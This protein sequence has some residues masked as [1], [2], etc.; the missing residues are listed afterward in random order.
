[1]QKLAKFIKVISD[2]NRLTIIKA[3]GSAAPSVTEIINST[4]LSQ[5]LV[6]FHLRI[7][8]KAGLVSSR[9]EGPFI[10][11]SLSDPAILGTLDNLSALAGL[12]TSFS[13]DN[14]LEPL[15]RHAKGR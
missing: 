11:Y 3:I 4:G 7:L 5:T 8:R 14:C 13:S 6:S 15:K 12:T 1:M 9:R 10:Y 2:S